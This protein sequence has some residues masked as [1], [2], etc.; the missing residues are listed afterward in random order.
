MSYLAPI[1][2]ELQQVEYAQIY[3]HLQLTETFDLPRGGLLLLRREL[4]QA[5]HTLEGWGGG[6]E[7]EQLQSLF[8]PPLPLDPVVRRLVQKPAPA[9][10]L[11]PDLQV[12]G[13]LPAKQRLVL[14]VLFIGRGVQALNPFVSLMQQLGQQ[15]LFQGSGRFFLEAVE[16]ENASGVRSMLWSAGEIQPVSPP[17][18]DLSW[19]L[20]QRTE[21]VASLNI[22][23]V[24]PLRLLKHSK[25][26]F[27]AGLA[28]LLP[29]ILRRVSSLLACHAG[30][31][32][33]DD[34]QRLLALAEQVTTKENRLRWQDWRR[35][36]GEQRAQDL[37]GLHGHLQLEGEAL[38]ELFWLLQL[39][40]LFNIGKSATY[41]AGQ[42]RLRTYR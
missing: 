26:L 14:P 30:V 34:P 11:K 41:G 19:L 31:E 8:R 37:G 23:I 5:L 10:I 27:K 29:F 20:E 39:G 3:F 33:I 12:T 4:L 28:E 36:Q 40:S 42:Y 21:S 24:S 16:T 1:P 25:P 38:A 22:E 15:G 7:V 13:L 32:V 18:S 35:L 17:V 9:F 2:E 6:S